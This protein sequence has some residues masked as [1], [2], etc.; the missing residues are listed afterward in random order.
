MLDAFSEK[1]TL[2]NFMLFIAERLG[3]DLTNNFDISDEFTLKIHLSGEQWNDACKDGFIDYRSANIISDI[4]RDLFAYYS[5]AVGKNIDFRSNY[6]EIKDVIVK[7]KISDGS[8][9]IEWLKD[10]MSTMV[11]KMN[12]WQIAGT[13]IGA[14]LI[15]F[16]Y[17]SFDSYNKRLTE[18]QRII[19]DERKNAQLAEIASNAIKASENSQATIRTIVKYMKSG[20]N[21]SNIHAGIKEISKDQLEQYIIKKEDDAVIERSI[22]VDG[23]FKLHS[24]KFGK[25][26]IQIE[27]GSFKKTALTKLLSDEDRRMLLEN[28]KGPIVSDELPEYDLQTSVVMKGNTIS[29]VYITG[30]GKQRSSAITPIEA[31][32]DT[33][34]SIQNT[35]QLHLFDE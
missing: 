1:M 4:Q 18:T 5:L 26:A 28:A 27:C 2:D 16:G 25:S 8:L 20:D 30:I 31:M 29:E 24:L 11:K 34:V 10:T 12:G 23:R 7:V 15:G 9:N 33:R 17:Y 3:T 6:D 13:V 21:F 35:E 22:Q 14:T 32:K 19:S